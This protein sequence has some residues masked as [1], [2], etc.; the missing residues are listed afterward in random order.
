MAEHAAETKAAKLT[1]RAL[2]MPRVEEKG[3][4]EALT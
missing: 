2:I 1:T 3:E 4:L